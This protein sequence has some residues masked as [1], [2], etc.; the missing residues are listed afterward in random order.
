M[1][2]LAQQQ[3]LR[4]MFILIAS[5]VVVALG[6]Q[7]FHYILYPAL[8]WCLARWFRRPI[9]TAPDRLRVTVITAAHNEAAII[10]EKIENLQRLRYPDLQILVVCD[11][12]T[13]ETEA[14]A[15]RYS[16][17][18]VEVLAVPQRQGKANALN[19]AVQHAS[20]DVIVISDANTI[21]E[22]D[23]IGHLVRNFH[24]PEVGLASGDITTWIERHGPTSSTVA[25]SEGL[26]WRYEAAIRRWESALGS[27]V[28]VIGALLAIRRNLYPGIP[29]DM[30]N[31]D[32]FLCLH[33]LRSGCR[34]IYEPQARSIR[35]S[36]RTMGDDAK[37]RQRMAAGR[38]Q[39]LLQPGN[40]PWASPLAAFFLFSHKFLRLFLP[41]LMA[42][43]LIG[44]IALFAAGPVPLAFQLTFLGQIGFYALAALGLVGERRKRKWR[45]PMLAYY[46]VRG[47]L[48][49]AEGLVQHLTGQRT[50]LWQKVD[51]I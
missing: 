30:I 15:R 28:S 21:C 38:H 47:N 8:L 6:L 20:G 16:A 18:G 3:G 29:A 22:P 49:V 50:V 9:R 39:L 43:A 32:V 7:A 36:S 1:P 13:D 40:W 42:V 12:C 24:D 25:R 35:R 27:T 34:V 48:G 37:R 17:W 11:G 2:S 41:F 4:V 51:R 26:Y 31:D 23:A 14:I 33:V 19:L 46:V 10:A 45:L 5:I 44:N